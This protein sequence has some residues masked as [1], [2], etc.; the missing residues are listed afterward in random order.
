V[1]YPL[2][3][4]GVYLWNRVGMALH[5]NSN[6]ALTSKPMLIQHASSSQTW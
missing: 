2:M 4:A 5:L 6:S 1:S 3:N